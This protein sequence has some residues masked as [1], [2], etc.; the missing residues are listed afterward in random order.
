MSDAAFTH[1]DSPGRGNVVHHR[2]N[3]VHPLVNPCAGVG[4][5]GTPQGKT[6]TPPGDFI[7]A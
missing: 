7:L 5:D 1:D 2:E 6:G 3:S 4:E